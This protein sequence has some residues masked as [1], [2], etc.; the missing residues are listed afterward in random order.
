MGFPKTMGHEAAIAKMYRE[1]KTLYEIG[2]AFDTSATTVLNCLKRTAAGRKALRLRREAKQ[3]ER[4]KR[5]E[6]DRAVAEMYCAGHT[7]DEVAKAFRI[8]VGT[9]GRILNREGVP[10]DY[11]AQQFAYHQEPE[12][13]SADQKARDRAIAEMYAAGHN[14]TEIAKAFGISTGSI[15]ARLKSEGV[16]PRNRY[17]H[18]RQFREAQK[19]RDAKAIALYRE[20]YAVR[21]IGEMLGV[22]PAIVA[23]ALDTAQFP[24]P[25]RWDERTLKSQAAFRAERNAEILRMHASGVA[26]ANIAR[27]C[28][29]SVAT[30]KSVTGEKP[31][32]QAK[33]PKKPESGLDRIARTAIAGWRALDARS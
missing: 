10:S 25:H 27:A 16:Q 17:N 31:K 7:Y 1:G 6:R 26:A 19:E 3:K 12:T 8:G 23:D 21:T 11:R 4:A 28:K 30:V 5:P 32:R 33:Q 15:S 13:R 14:F 24:R 18:S 29:C 22:E 9:I 20:G 2:D